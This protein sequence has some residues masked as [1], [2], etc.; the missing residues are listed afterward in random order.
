MGDTYDV[1][2]V[3]GGPVGLGLAVE[4]GQAGI[5]VLLVERHATPVKVP[6]GQNLTQ[7]T[8]EHFLAWDAEAA[9]RSARTIPPEYGIGGLTAYGTLLGEYRYDW[10]A[11]ERVREYY[12]TDNERLPQYCTEQVLR[13]R[14]A[15]LPAVV[16]ALG[17]TAQAVSQEEGGVTIRY[18]DTAG[19]EHVATAQYLVGCDGSRSLIRREAQITETR[20]DPDRTMALIVFRSDGLNQLLQRFPGK[21]FYNVLTPEL[22][23]YWMFL[24][25][26][27]LDGNWF[28]HAPVPDSARTDAFDFAGYLHRAVGAEFDVAIEYTGFWDLRFAQADAYRAGRIFLAGDAAHSHPPY[29]GYGINTGLEDARNLGWKLAAVLHGWGGAHLLDSY[30]AERHP[31]FESTAR[32]FIEKSIREDSRFLARYSPARDQDAFETEWRNRGTGAKAEVESFAPHYA[33]SPIVFG[34]GGAVCSAVGVHSFAARPGHH[35]APRAMSNGSAAPDIARA[36]LTLLALDAE[37]DD[38]AA[39][40]TAANACRVPLAVLHDTFAGGREAYGARLVLL[41]PDGFVGWAG[42]RLDTAASAIIAR[43]TG[44]DGRESA[45]TR[46]IRS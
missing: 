19:T 24:G 21:S 8:M 33:G 13:D 22:E 29:G 6:K 15:A 31:V 16:T 43:V 25:R 26:V 44:Q 46:A 10:L 3:G 36:G 14:V 4:L 35:L 28:F 12:R 1:V 7:R 34:P 5:S 9:L 27:D 45:A 41:R 2:I 37:A 18:R 17:C 23:G 42:D 39:F 30:H 40:E 32:D 20:S 11:R 38:I